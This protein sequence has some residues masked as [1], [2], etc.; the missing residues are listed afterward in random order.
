MK[1]VL[2]IG[3]GR[4]AVSL[5]S[6]LSAY[7]ESKNIAIT[8]VDRDPELL[9]RRSAEYPTIDVQEMD[10]SE[11]TAL[12]DLISE[13]HVVIS[14]LPA[15]L[16]TPVIKACIQLRRPVVTASYV[17]D[18]V[19]GLETAATE[20][21]VLVLMEMGLDPGIDHMS[22]KR[23]L[24]SL[25]KKGAKVTLFKSFTGGL[26]APLSDTNP[27][28]YKLTWN[29]KNVVLSGLG[30]VKFRRNRR[31]KY[32]PYHRLFERLESVKVDGF[33]DFEAYPNRDSLKYESKYG[34]SGV[35]TIMRGTL[36]RPGFCHSWNYLV[37]LGYTNDHVEL[38][39]LEKFSYRDF[40]NSL[41]A[42]D[43][44]LS[45]EEKMMN[46]LGLS[47]QEFS[48]LE[49]LGLFS[50]ELIGVTKATPAYVLQKLLEDKWRLDPDDKDMVVMKHRI[51]YELEGEGRVHE[52]SLVLMGE[53]ADST[54]MA[55]TVG[56]PLGIATIMILDGKIERTGVQ[57]PIHED[58]YVPVL[59]ELEN[60]GVS[61]S[62]QDY[63]L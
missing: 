1:H 63:S 8:L 32:I 25:K 38:N 3:A 59:N 14:L 15:A 42:Y 22:A 46:Y 2:I 19:R 40:T 13:S 35:S 37:Q 20:N 9:K 10:T 57:V 21:N 56:L 36:R 34:L 17:S 44:V 27:W 41:L 62:V 48:K 12:V 29:P 4:S 52:S 58:I 50:E 45:V 39:G 60:L 6:Y 24:D 23:D 5:L 16:H 51:E 28:N 11:L 43:P 54:S 47:T 33:G 26:V 53:N 30:G 18:E 55:K 61:F 49:W 7:S 31:Y